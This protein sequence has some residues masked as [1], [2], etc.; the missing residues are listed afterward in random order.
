MSIALDPVDGRNGAT[1]TV[2]LAAEPWRRHRRRRGRHETHVRTAPS[3]LPQ[4]FRAL[5]VRVSARR[6]ASRKA[7]RPEGHARG[8]GGEKR[9]DPDPRGPKTTYSLPPRGPRA[10][11]PR[12]ARPWRVFRQVRGAEPAE[13]DARSAGRRR[14]SASAAAGGSVAAGFFVGFPDAMPSPS[15]SS[16]RLLL[17]R[18]RLR[19]RLEAGVSSLDAGSRRRGGLVWPRAPPPPPPSSRA[20]A[21]RR[22]AA[23]ASLFPARSSSPA[24]ISRR[25]PHPCPAS[26]H[27]P[28]TSAS[29]P[30]RDDHVLVLSSSVCLC[31]M[32]SSSCAARSVDL[33]SSSAGLAAAAAAAAAA[34]EVVSS[35]PS[36]SSS[37]SVLGFV[38]VPMGDARASYTRGGV[39]R[40]AIGAHARTER[41]R[42]RRRSRLGRRRGDDGVPGE[43]ACVRSAPSAPRGARGTPTTSLRPPDL[44]EVDAVEVPG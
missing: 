13:R 6:D 17:G 38:V 18:R 34:A 40:P 39:L 14:G 4:M 43:G 20:S 29:C 36:T 9:S 23:A 1:A 10:R 22:R 16:G 3:A 8:G 26:E 35:F 42:R 37:P 27:R 30:G 11:T 41:A 24:S 12:A 5:P 32:H 21:P 15:P 28:P 44:L 25:R 7:E 19:L 2:R 31:V 33:S